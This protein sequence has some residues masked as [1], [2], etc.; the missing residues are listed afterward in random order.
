MRVLL[1]ILHKRHQHEMARKM[2]STTQSLFIDSPTCSARLALDASMSAKGF[3]LAALRI[4][5][6][7]IFPAVVKPRGKKHRKF[8]VIARIFAIVDHAAQKV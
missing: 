5:R 6:W 4:G 7:W 8:I 2:C 1:P 3:H